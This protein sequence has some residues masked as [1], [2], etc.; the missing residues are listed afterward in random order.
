MSSGVISIM[1]Y[2]SSSAKRK[3]CVFSA[4]SFPYHSSLQTTGCVFSSPHSVSGTGQHSASAACKTASSA[5]ATFCP[6]PANSTIIF[7]SAFA[8]SLASIPAGSNPRSSHS[9]AYIFRRSVSSD[10][11][12]IYRPFILSNDMPL[13]SIFNAFPAYLNSPTPFRITIFPNA[14]PTIKL[15]FR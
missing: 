12:S 11:F 13:F 10:F 6:S 8:Q 7:P 5:G 4:A 2:S 1:S 3:T 15:F 9:L 14:T